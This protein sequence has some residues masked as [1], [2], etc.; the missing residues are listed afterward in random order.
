MWASKIGSWAAAGVATSSRAVT[1]VAS[2]R[3]IVAEMVALH[4]SAGYSSAQHAARRTTHATLVATAGNQSAR[5]CGRDRC[6]AA[7]QGL[8]TGGR[9]DR[10]RAPARTL[11]AEDR[12]H[13]AHVTPAAAR[14]A[15]EMVRSRDH[16]ERGVLRAV[17]R[18]S[19][20]HA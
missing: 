8:G 4:K 17:P 1:S 7:A 16:T 12:P 10:R 2:R 13:S 6:W 15:D 14:D 19:H 3:R 11:P 5:R 9:P 20:P 18:V